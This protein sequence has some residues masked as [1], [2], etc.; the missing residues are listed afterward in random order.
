MIG[1]GGSIAGDEMPEEEEGILSSSS[2][3]SSA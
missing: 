3:S 1:T 2:S